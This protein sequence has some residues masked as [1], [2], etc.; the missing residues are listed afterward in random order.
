MTTTKETK[1]FVDVAEKMPT[2]FYLNAA[3]HYSKAVRKHPRFAD[4]L[5]NWRETYTH[6]GVH[7]NIKNEA[8]TLLRVARN[9]LRTETDGSQVVGKH[10]LDC[11]IAEAFCAYAHNDAAACVDELYDAV[12]VLMRMIAVVEG[13][14]RLG[15][16]E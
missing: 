5:F 11:E 7:L 16:E 8:D 12:A 14:Q 10:L 3:R 9:T 15:G 13:K 1:E 4:A 6:N 2:D